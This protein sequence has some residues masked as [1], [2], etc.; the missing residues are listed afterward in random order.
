MIARLQQNEYVLRSNAASRLTRDFGPDFL[1]N[2]NNYHSGGHVG[3]QPSS[4]SISGGGGGEISVNMTDFTNA[5]NA[6]L[7]TF[8]QGMQQIV[9]PLAEAGNNL[10][11]VDGSV[12]TMN[13]KQ[14]VNVSIPNHS[15]GMGDAMESLA[16]EAVR[17]GLNQVLTKQG[18]APRPANKSSVTPIGKR[19]GLT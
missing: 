16:N 1:N 4:T 14:D 17:S 6:T 11:K 15:K 10:S 5:L 8:T 13:S 12:I 18:A 9:V 19:Q 7:Q 2:M 3:S